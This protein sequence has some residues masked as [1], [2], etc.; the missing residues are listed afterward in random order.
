M[1]DHRYHRQ[2]EPE[3]EVRHRIIEFHV[4]QMSKKIDSARCICD[5]EGSLVEVRHHIMNQSDK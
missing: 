2:H 1:S 4:A 5:F 3:P